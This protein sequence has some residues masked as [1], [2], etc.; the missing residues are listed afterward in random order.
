MSRGGGKPTRKTAISWHCVGSSDVGYGVRSAG[1]GFWVRPYRATAADPIKQ[2]SPSVAFDF[3][4]VC[5]LLFAQALLGQ[6][7]LPVVRISSLPCSLFS[8]TAKNHSIKFFSKIVVKAKKPFQ[9]NDY[10][11]EIKFRNALLF[12]N[13]NKRIYWNFYIF[14]EHVFSP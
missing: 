3:G 11:P 12:F 14:L 5:R 6:L 7:Q 8:Y 9:E 13:I 4:D 1:S 10:I 2:L